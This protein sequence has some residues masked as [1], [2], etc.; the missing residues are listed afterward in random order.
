MS[1]WE[2]NRSLLSLDRSL[3]LSEERSNLTSFVPSL[4]LSLDI[5]LNNELNTTDSK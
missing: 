2:I 3:S 1:E 4:F 5:L